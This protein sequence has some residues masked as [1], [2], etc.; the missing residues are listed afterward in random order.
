MV[1][2][3]HPLSTAPGIGAYKIE[4]PPNIP[5]GPVLPVIPVNPVAPVVPVAPVGPNNAALTIGLL[6]HLPVGPAS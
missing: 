3:L 5:L 2:V 1:K 4:V 6:T